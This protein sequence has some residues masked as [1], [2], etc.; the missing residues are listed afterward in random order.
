MRK[1]EDI[2]IT[3]L[4]HAD[5]GMIPNHPIYPLLLYKNVIEKNDDIE[6]ILSENNWLGIWEG[7]VAPYHHYHSISHEVVVVKDGSAT[8]HLGGEDG[9][10]VEVKA[11][12]V[13]II[14]A[15][16]GHKNIDS[17]SDFAV[18][19]AY[20][21]GM[22]YDFCYGKKEERSQN[23]ENIRK[24]PMPD[25]DPVFGKAGPLFKYWVDE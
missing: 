13:A 12:D 14:P 1:A 17:S 22:D 3:P 18:Y 16:F 8:L 9:T 15:G 4:K 6:N 23:L 5:D 11:G 24:V 7:G 19:G 10:K 2:E 20:P 25:K 21:D